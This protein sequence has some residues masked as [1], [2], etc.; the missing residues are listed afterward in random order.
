ME[1]YI[2]KKT[3]PFAAPPTT[4]G[5]ASLDKV[6]S[7][8]DNVENHIQSLVTEYA[9]KNPDADPAGRDQ[10]IARQLLDPKEAACQTILLASGANLKVLHDPSKLLCVPYFPLFSTPH[11]LIPFQ[12]QRRR[13]HVGRNRRLQHAL[14]QPWNHPHHLFRS[15]SAPHHRPCIL[16]AP[17]GS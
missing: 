3:G 1:A 17:A 8:I 9:K 15:H 10:L 5:F 11:K 16:Q 13:R 7:G 12:P 2:T 4:T 6:K 14:P